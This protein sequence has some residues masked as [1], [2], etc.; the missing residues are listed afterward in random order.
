M[1]FWHSDQLICTHLSCHLPCDLLSNVLLVNLT[2]HPKS[3]GLFFF[4]FAVLPLPHAA[5]SV[6]VVKS[7]Q[8]GEKHRLTN[9]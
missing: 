6:L 7:T 2:L 9:K 1:Q 5:S 4:F 8:V 3:T